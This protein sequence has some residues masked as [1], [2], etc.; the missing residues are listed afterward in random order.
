MRTQNSFLNIVS[1]CM[2]YVVLMLSGFVIRKLFAETLGMQCVG[3]DGRFTDYVAVLTIIEINLGMNF[4]YKLY[5]P[6]ARRDI[7]QISLIITFLK[8]SYT[9]IVISILALGVFF[10]YFAVNSI[11]EG[12]DKSWLFRV[13]FLYLADTVCSYFYYHKRMMIIANQQSRVIGKIRAC[14]LIV[15]SIVQ[16]LI[17]KISKSFEIYVFAKI[18]S[19]ITENIFISREFKKKY[20][21]IDTN[22]KINLSEEKKSEIFKNIKAMLFHK[23]GGAGLNQI[24]SI[25]FGL[26]ALSLSESGIYYNYVLI[27]TALLGISSEFFKGITAS[28]GNLITTEKTKKVEENFNVIFLINFFIYSFFCSS[29]FCISGPFMKFWISKPD[30][31]F[32]LIMTAAITL[33]LYIY[34]MR[35]SIGMAKESVGIYVQ[36]RYFPILETIVNFAFSYFLTRK[37]GIIGVVIGS[38]LSSSISFI[39]YPFFVYKILFKKSSVEY[40]KKYLIYAIISL[41]EVIICHYCTQIFDT[42]SNFLKIATNLAICLIIS[43]IANIMIFYRT[44]EFSRIVSSFF[45]LFNR[46]R[47]KFVSKR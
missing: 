41:F 20:S 23:I 6:I 17:L 35:Q 21:D 18:I 37:I 38:I 10:S 36:D 40:Y 30:A 1:N 28:F 22:V 29:F 16:F 27:V 31:H 12:F 13:F 14:C 2:C 32:G 34:G 42:Q 39:T 47:D 15:L 44:R 46:F 45:E 19:R 24:S 33:N 43:V 11:N 9:I 5:D 26:V 4:I 7:E 3:I 25:I 8:K